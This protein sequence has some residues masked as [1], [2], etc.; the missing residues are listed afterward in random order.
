MS[1]GDRMRNALGGGGPARLPAGAS[2][3]QIEKFKKQKAKEEAA[4]KARRGR[5]NVAVQRYGDAAGIPFDD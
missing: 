4:S 1:L 2:T 3:K 5:H